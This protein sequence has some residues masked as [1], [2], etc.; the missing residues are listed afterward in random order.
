[1]KVGVCG[2]ACEKCPRMVR[3][4]CPSGEA[5]CRPRE[6]PFCKVATCAHRRGVELCFRCPEFPCETTRLG[7]IDYG[8]CTYIAGKEG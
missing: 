7:P 5:G 2:V 8:Y 3:G 4:A 6:S 1:V